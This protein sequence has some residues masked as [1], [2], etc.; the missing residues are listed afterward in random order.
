MVIFYIWIFGFLCCFGP[1]YLI[2]DPIV[3]P[4]EAAPP[5][6]FCA[7]GISLGW[8]VVVPCYLSYYISKYIYEY[9]KN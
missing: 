4:D 3:S 6:A 9:Y 8:F 5:V 1:S 2:L 7:F